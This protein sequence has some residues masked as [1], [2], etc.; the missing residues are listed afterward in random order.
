MSITA[1]G[2]K[3][4]MI[5]ITAEEDPS[6]VLIMKRPV[7]MQPDLVIYIYIVRYNGDRYHHVS[8]LKSARWVRGVTIAI[9]STLHD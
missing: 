1:G 3:T 6:L 9:L 5:C 7:V 2:N 8:C 4:E